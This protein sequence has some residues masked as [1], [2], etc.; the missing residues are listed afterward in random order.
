[1]DDVND[2]SK[3]LNT[4]YIYEHLDEVNLDIINSESNE[5]ENDFP[6]DLTIVETN[7]ENT[8]LL[9]DTVDDIE[10]KLMY[11]NNE[12]VTPGNDFVHD[13]VG[14][15]IA[16]AA[17]EPLDDQIS[18]PQYFLNTFQETVEPLT[19]EAV[20]ESENTTD[21]S[22]ARNDETA[23]TRRGRAKKPSFKNILDREEQEALDKVDRELIHKRRQEAVSE[24]KNNAQVREAVLKFTEKSTEVNER[25]SEIIRSPQDCG[26]KDI[27]IDSSWISMKIMMGT[28]DQKNPTRCEDAVLDLEKL[29]MLISNARH[30]RSANNKRKLDSVKI[31]L[32]L[33]RTSC[34]VYRNGSVLIIVSKPLSGTVGTD[35]STAEKKIERFK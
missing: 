28:K 1:M 14:Y 20:V 35:T 11:N 29:F 27:T 32:N 18:L 23:S 21:T 34:D 2:I 31:G 13:F 26:E 24:R 17:T 5:E 6:V 10:T 4:D 16:D 12:D 33:P 9:S 25:L 3:Y 8:S 22:G 7:N 30:R 19:P 15:S